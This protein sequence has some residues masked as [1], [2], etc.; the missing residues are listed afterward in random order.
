MTQVITPTEVRYSEPTPYSQIRE[1]MITCADRPVVVITEV[2]V[3][4]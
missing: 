1:I 4:Q 3:A 2:P